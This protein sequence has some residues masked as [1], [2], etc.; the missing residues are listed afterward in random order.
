MRGKIR[1][2]YWTLYIIAI[3]TII[4]GI[5]AYILELGEEESYYWTF[6]KF[7]ELSNFDQPPMLGWFIQLFSHNLFL[8]NEFFLRLSSIA[9]GSACIWIVFIIGRRIKGDSAGFYSALLYTV[10][11]YLSVIAGLFIMPEA[12]QTLFYL[13]SLY[14]LLEGI[15][16]RNKRCPESDYLC[17]MALILAGLFI[18]LSILSKFSSALLWPAVFIYAILYN[19]SLLKSRSLYLSLSI[20]LLSLIPIYIWNVKN[21]FVGV[22]YLRSLVNITSGLNSNHFFYV[23]AAVIVV[24]NPV[25]IYIIIK[26]LRNYKKIHFIGFNYMHLLLSLSL[27]IILLS[28]LFSFFST[29]FIYAASLGVSPLIFIAGAY[30]SEK[31][32]KTDPTVL[33]TSIKVGIALFITSSI[34]IITHYYTGILSFPGLR[35]AKELQIGE[36]DVTLTRYGINDLSGE[37]AKIRANDIEDGVMPIN[38]YILETNYKRAA[39]FDYYLGRPN[40]IAVKTFGEQSQTRKYTLITK[41]RGGLKKGESAYYIASSLYKD[42]ISKLENLAFKKIE[43]ASELYIYRAGRPAVRYTVYR[44]HYL[45]KCQ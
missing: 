37:F 2:K 30:I 32:S 4:R 31:I 45:E 8:E 3:S 28:A 42:S 14:F 1:Y 21:D 5:T 15:I 7:P 24:N 29:S 20:S 18:G 44:L 35:S 19:K 13:L 39:Q 23:L 36:G 43:K 40:G 17:S 34:L 33:P 16:P 22:E 6:A 26:A 10:S 9:T 25:N 11:F 27:P 41:K 12:P 38:S